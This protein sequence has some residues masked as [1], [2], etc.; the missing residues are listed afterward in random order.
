MDKSIAVGQSINRVEGVSVVAIAGH[1][2]FEASI[3][4]KSV[5][6]EGVTA[7]GIFKDII[8]GKSA[9]LQIASVV[10]K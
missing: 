1:P 9:T 5:D 3:L 6:T 4:S 2:V 8:E 7:P 10:N